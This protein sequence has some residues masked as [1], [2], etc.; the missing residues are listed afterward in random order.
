ME[1]K[2]L[3]D[4]VN[5]TAAYMTNVGYAIG[6]I[7]CYKAIWNKFIRYS[8]TPYYDRQIA[9]DFLNTCFGLSEELIQSSRE[10][11]DRKTRGALRS[12]NTLE[13]FYQNGTVSFRYFRDNDPR[14]IGDV[15][16]E[17]HDLFFKEYLQYFKT[18]HPSTSWEKSTILSLGSFLQYVYSCGITA[19]DLLRRETVFSYISLTE[20]WGIPLKVTRYAQLTFYLAWVYKKGII[21]EDLSRLIPKVKRNPPVLARVWSNEEIDRILAVIDTSNPVGKRNYA[22]FLI[23]ARMTLRISDVVCLCFSSIDWRKKQ[24]SICQEKTKE[25]VTLPMSREIVDALIDYLKNG[26]PDSE[27]DRVFLSQQYPFNPIASHNNLYPELKKY[28]RRAGITTTEGERVGVHTFR[29][30][31]TTNMLTNGAGIDEVSMIDGHANIDSTKPYVRNN[32]SLLS[33][34]AIEP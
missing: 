24:F 34:C 23:A 19:P 16:E 6:T 21:H 17:V 26:R 7:G 10:Q 31:G 3:Q 25:I 1:D 28:I 33:L 27:S 14:R 11:L 18:K 5:E 13:D 4:L 29:H 30:S 9:L 22:I 12:I 20:R 15:P 8:S 32:P 2:L